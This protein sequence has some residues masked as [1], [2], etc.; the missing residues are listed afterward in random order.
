M[1]MAREEFESWESQNNKQKDFEPNEQ[2]V[3]EGG[4][5]ASILSWLVSKKHVGDVVQQ[6]LRT[7]PPFRR[8]QP[9]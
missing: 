2:Q 6:A 7:C 5:P 4:E 8:A 9:R 3:S 1:A